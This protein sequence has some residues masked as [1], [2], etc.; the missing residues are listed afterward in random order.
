MKKIFY[1][2]TALFILAAC[3]TS[4]DFLTRSN[5]ERALLDAVKFLSKNPGD[6]NARQAVALL[7]PRLLQKHLA[8]VDALKAETGLSKYD[9]LAEELGILQKMHDAIIN[10]PAAR[11]LLNPVDYQAQVNENRQLAA[12]AYYREADLYLDKEGRDNAKK[13]YTYFKKADKWVPGFKDAGAKM[14]VAFQQAMVNVLVKPV[15]DNSFFFNAGWGNTGLNYSNEYFQQTLIRELGGKNAVRYP[16]R[17]YSDWEARRDNVRP[18]WVVDLNL[19]NLYIPQPSNYTYSHNASKQVEVGRDSS[20]HSLYQ[21]VYATVYITRQ[22]F[23][24]RAQMEVY[25]TET[26]TRRNISDHTYSEEYS[27]QEEHAS[28]TGD[29][30]ALDAND[31]ALVNNSR[32]I[33]TDPRQED[34]LNELYRKLYPQVKNCI[35]NAV[36]W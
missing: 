29:S 7:Y 26:N 34:V 13:A 1:T 30:R 9:N 16:A 23:R 20:G 32:N 15:E 21:T 22:S 33:N 4:K 35:L 28:Y 17:F 36:D 6:S 3:K 27:W 31:W 24:A 19:R 14:N 5:E 11:M 25:I 18:D 10:E 2:I 8:R 12:D